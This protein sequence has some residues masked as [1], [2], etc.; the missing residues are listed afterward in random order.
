MVLG[1]AN[2]RELELIL[3]VASIIRRSGEQGAPGIAFGA[4]ERNVGLA[5]ED[6]A[7]IFY[8]IITVKLIRGAGIRNKEINH[9]NDNCDRGSGDARDFVFEDKEDE[10]RNDGKT[11]DNCDKVAR[12]VGGKVAGVIDA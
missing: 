3:Y 6:D 12:R 9:R 2:A 8:H 5:N 11:I 7:T 1:R 4:K 10:N